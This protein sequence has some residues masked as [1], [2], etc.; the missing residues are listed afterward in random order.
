MPTLQP[1]GLPGSEPT[2]QRLELPAPLPSSPGLTTPPLP[3]SQQPPAR[4]TLLT[5]DQPWRPLCTAEHGWHRAPRPTGWGSPLES[6]SAGTTRDKRAD[7]ISKPGV[8][9]VPCCLCRCRP[10]E[11]ELAGSRHGPARP[12]HTPPA[13]TRKHVSRGPQAVAPEPRGRPLTSSSPAPSW[14]PLSK[15]FLKP[16]SVRSPL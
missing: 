16:S 11:A 1:Q 5:W 10:R 3:A 13:P 2:T 6:P 14:P 8:Q 15:N 9:S 12:S 4:H 7:F